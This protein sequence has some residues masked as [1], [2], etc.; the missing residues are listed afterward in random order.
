MRFENFVMSSGV[1]RRCNKVTRATQF[2]STLNSSTLTSE[3]TFAN[4]IMHEGDVGAATHRSKNS[5]VRTV[6][7]PCIE[8][9]NVRT[10]QNFIM[11]KSDVGFTA[12]R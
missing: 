8:L 5:K 9:N 2:T 10:F 3:L 1:T 4:F 12:Y 7:I 6:V 11:S